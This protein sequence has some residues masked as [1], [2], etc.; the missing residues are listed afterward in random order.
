M[1]CVGLIWA[2]LSKKPFHTTSL[3]LAAPLSGFL[4]SVVYHWDNAQS[5][6]IPLSIAAL[7]VTL[8]AWLAALIGYRCI[9]LNQEPEQQDESQR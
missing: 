3:F 6:V 1:I 7:L 4:V 5:L 8:S 2:G 9:Q